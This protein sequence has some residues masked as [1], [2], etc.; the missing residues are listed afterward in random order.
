MAA[1]PPLDVVLHLRLVV[2]VVLVGIASRELVLGYRSR[3]IRVHSVRSDARRDHEPASAGLVRGI[4]HVLGAAQVDG[5]SQLLVVDLGNHECEMHDRLTAAQQVMHARRADVLP[6]EAKLGMTDP[7][8]AQVDADHLLDLRV[9]EQ[10]RSDYRAE[11]TC[12]AGYRNAHPP[13][14]RG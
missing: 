4:D 1:L 3:V 7:R 9:G 12:Y 11:V 8:I 10:Q 14:C 2:E 6:L 5:V 13:H